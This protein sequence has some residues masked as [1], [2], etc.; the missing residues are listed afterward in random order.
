MLKGKG[1]NKKFTFRILKGIYN[2]EDIS[3]LIRHENIMVATL[4]SFAAQIAGLINLIIAYMEKN[5]ANSIWPIL[6]IIISI[7]LYIVPSRSWNEKIKL[8]IM[9]VLC[10]FISSIYIF[11]YYRIIDNMICCILFIIILIV[12]VRIEK[13]MLYYIIAETIGIYI[14]ILNNSYNRGIKYNI[15]QAIFIFTV[16]GIALIVNK[17]HHNL[18]INNL[19]QIEEIRGQKEK[20]STL[21]KELVY[22]EKKLRQQNDILIKCNEQIKKDR[23]NLNYMVNHDNLTGLPNRKMFMDELT[24]IIKKSKKSKSEFAVVF[25][26]LDNFKRINDTMGHYIGDLYLCEISKRFT[27]LINERDILGRLSGDEFAMIVR[28]Y[29]DKNTL[30]KYIESLKNSFGDSFSL[31]SYKFKSSASF[32]VSIFP[33]DAEDAIELLKLADKALYR[34]KEKGKNGIEFFDDIG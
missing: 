6:T 26:D 29:S 23:M 25:I 24:L 11:Q 2:S 1:H 28:R 10:V 22:S 19:R 30:F 34:V 18:I 9:S 13:V 17:I 5:I 31:E 3:E 21:Y 14:F 8:H 33:K 7:I 27:A 12:S 32:G 4:I 16:I 15:I 20:I